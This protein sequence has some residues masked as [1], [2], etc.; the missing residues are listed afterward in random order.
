MIEYKHEL[1]LF[2]LVTNRSIVNITPK[3][4]FLDWIT[5]IDGSDYLDDQ[6]QFEPISF[7]IPD[8]E[9]KT[10][11]DDWLIMNY[12]LLFEIRLNY[13]CIDKTLWPEVR[14]LEVF[15]DWFDVR[16]CNLVLDLEEGPICTI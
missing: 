3:R 2:P 9:C 16:Y 15:K 11:F 14:T 7:L 10:D 1:D 8:F 6:N 5:Y 13:S 12:K 4:I